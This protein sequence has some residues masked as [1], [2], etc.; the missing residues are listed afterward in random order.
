VKI[1]LVDYGVGNFIKIKQILE[2]NKIPVIIFDVNRKFESDLVDTLI[3]PG[4]GSFD[5]CA[6]ALQMSGNFEKIIQFANS[7]KKLIGICA[8]AQL[9]FER[10]EEGKLPGLGWIKGTVTRFNFSDIKSNVRLNIPHMGWNVI[11]PK[12][13]KNLF[14]GLEDEARFYFIHSYHV[15]CS[16]ASDVL[17]TANYG[18]EFTCSVRHDNIWGVQFHPEK[19]H[20]FGIQV[21]K[22]FLKEIGYA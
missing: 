5:A 21:F 15:N 11:N 16:N 12:I 8:G 9:L 20:Q 18:H 14:L 10:S 1:G 3:L 22:N 6:K 17:A 13:Y 19:S 2:Q 7:G 4:V